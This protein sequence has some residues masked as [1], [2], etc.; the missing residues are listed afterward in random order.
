MKL[1]WQILTPEGLFKERES[2][3]VYLEA[4]KGPIGILPGYTNYIGILREKSVMK[5]VDNAVERFYLLEGGAFEVKEGVLYV[6]PLKASRLK[7]REEA[8][9]VLKDLGYT[10]LV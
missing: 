10:L 2:D 8:V 3:A 4:S 5:A 6:Y 1:A 9:Q 7:N